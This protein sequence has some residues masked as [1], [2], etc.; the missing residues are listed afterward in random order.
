MNHP[1][2]VLCLGAGYVATH[3]TKVLKPA[4]KA[5]KVHLTVVDRNNY[6]TFHGL[7]AEMLT[8]QVQPGQIISP[9]RRITL[10]ADFHNAEIDSINIEKQVVTTSRAIDGREYVLPYDH[11]ILSL[12]SVD[13]LLLYAGIGEHTFRLKNYWDC[14][15]V[16]NHILQMLELAEFE[17][18]PEEKQRLL[19]FVIAGG[20]YAGVEVATEL[21]VF[22]PILLRKEYPRIRPDEIKIIIIHSGSTLLPELADRFPGLIRYAVRRIEKLGFEV[23]LN[24]R[25]A[26]ATSA[27]AI[28]NNERRIPTYT[29]ISCTGTAQS[30]LLDTL[31][32]ERDERGRI[33]TDDKVN[34]IGTK[35][36]W[37][38]G[39]CAA[40]PERTGGTCP[41][42]A[43]Y[44][45]M[46][47][48]Q[49]AKNILRRI[50]NKPPKTYRS[51][52][53]G[54]VCCLA[55]RR[56]VGHAKGIPMVGFPAWLLWRVTMFVYLPTW[57]RRIRVLLDWMVWPFVGRD[58]VSVQQDQKMGISTLLFEPEQIIIHEGD[59]G[60][61]LYIISSGEV[62]VLKIDNGKEQVL[63]TL[64]SGRYF[65]ETAVYEMCR[66][67]ASV[68]A[69]T[70][71][72]L[73]EVKRDTAVT[74]TGVL[75]G[76]DETLRQLSSTGTAEP[77]PGSDASPD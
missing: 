14:F 66:R 50:D 28:L 53:L 57:D 22:F 34:V 52:A 37:A 36:I 26:S 13:D 23:H 3:A 55:G 30:P 41:P 19:T 8:G 74:L 38:G 10:P 77:D 35:N 18:D 61:S 64:G 29:I 32:F 75:S 21:S 11:L 4:I 59:V 40:V 24:T 27:E 1:V 20:G 2:R 47:G 42:L 54:D 12:G 9:A 7:I 39:D 72:K 46:V 15:E 6:H 58:I 76:I 51:T 62:E 56:A 44:A 65:G 67:T 17:E 31:P 43:I 60:H 16:R 49:I 63:A 25:L 45:M 33:K 68:R 48:K 71:V 5:G 69:K 73:L 70:R